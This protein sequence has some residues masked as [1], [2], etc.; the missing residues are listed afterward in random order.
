MG[1]T[2]STDNMSIIQELSDLPNT[3]DG[4][5]AQE[6]KAKFDLGAETLQ[7]DLNRLM[8]EIEGDIGSAN[9]GATPVYEGDTSPDNVQDKLEM[10]YEAVQGATLGQIPDGS[11]TKTKLD[12][13]FANKIA[14]K[15]GTMQTNLNAEKLGGIKIFDLYANAKYHTP[16]Y[17]KAAEPVFEENS[18][19]TLM[20]MLQL[21]FL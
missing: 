16:T 7:D 6:L 10:I 18:I 3:D 5:T 4:L 21:I 15:D 9:V 14:E 8:N 19:P 1:F 13:T 17:T 20:V 11:I 2:R 12:Q